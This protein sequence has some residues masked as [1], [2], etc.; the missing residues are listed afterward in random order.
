MKTRAAILDEVGREYEVVDLEL[1]PPKAGEVLVRMA[2]SGICH[3]DE[4]I[5]HSPACRLPLVGGHEGSGVVEAVGEGV[6]DLRPGDHVATSFIDVCRRCRWCVTGQTYLCDNGM[7]IPTG[8]LS[9]GTVRFHHD[10][11]D[12]GAFCTVGSFAEYSVLD[13]NGCVKIDDDLPLDVAALLS[14]GV[15]TGW[16][17][18]VNSAEVRAGEVVAIYG[19]GGVGANAVQGA[20]LAGARAVIVTDPVAFKREFAESV[21]ATHTFAD[22]AAAQEFVTLYTRGVGV[23][24]SIVTTGSITPQDI[25][26]A[27]AATRKGGTIV[28]TAVAHDSSEVTLQLPST[29]VT[30]LVQRIQ[31][32]LYG[33]CNPHVHV[34]HLA[35]LYREGRLKLDELITNRYKLDDV[36]HAFADMRNGVNIR[37]IIEHRS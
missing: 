32:S 30:S 16:G 35:T 9:D 26:A 10:G 31:G 25:A 3:S 8:E 11:R 19:S 18:A 14:C 36:A 23:D 4:G 17:S 20:A 28:L 5:R 21:G 2:Y 29:W 24:K 15:A 34:P 7:R 33:Q 37:G 22:A 27:R 1:D 6:V 12:L 13:Q